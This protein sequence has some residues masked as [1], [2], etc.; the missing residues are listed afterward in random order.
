MRIL[1]ITPT[2][3]DVS[4]AIVEGTKSSP[5]VVPLD[6][7]KQKFPAGKNENDLLHDLYRFALSLLQD[8][9]VEKIVI[10]QAGTSQYGKTSSIRVKTEAVFQIAAV[11]GNK[12]VEVIHPNT[13]KAQIKKFESIAG[14]TP[15]AVLNAGDNFKPKPWK[16]T[17]LT[18]WVGLE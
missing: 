11:E 3:K 7:T 12:P 2:S 15:E 4:W 6:S 8:K 17:V 1:G 9:E 18:A 13:L 14:D 16:D 5:V 10:L